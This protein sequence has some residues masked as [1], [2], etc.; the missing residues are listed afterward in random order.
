M[1]FDNFTRANCISCIDLAQILNS[2]LR[3]NLV[4]K[5]ALINNRKTVY[6][7]SLVTAHSFRVCVCCLPV[8]NPLNTELNPICQ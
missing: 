6:A 1:R 8:V 3:Q 5:V 4:E 7:D 2:H